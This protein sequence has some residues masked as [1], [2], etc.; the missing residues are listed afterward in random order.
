M[1]TCPRIALKSILSPAMRVKRRRT[2]RADDPQV[3]EAV[4]VSDA[5][6][7]IKD[8]SH[9]SLAPDFALTA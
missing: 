3:L 6:Y 7:M 4:V 5:V 2:V 9:P 1:Q 8:Q